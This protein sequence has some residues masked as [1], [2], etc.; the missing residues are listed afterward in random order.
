MWII[1]IVIAVIIFITLES[2]P[3]KPKN[4]EDSEF[5]ELLSKYQIKLPIE[6]DVDILNAKLF[7]QLGI[8]IGYV[9]INGKHVGRI[10]YGD[11]IISEY[12]WDSELNKD[13]AKCMTTSFL[14]NHK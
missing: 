7:V 6:W 2:F 12:I 10:L 3:D 11:I 9:K 14:K 8:T 1:I 4:D 5:R 13:I